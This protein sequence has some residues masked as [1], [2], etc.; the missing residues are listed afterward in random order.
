MESL[1]ALAKLDD[2][3]VKGKIVFLNAPVMRRTRDGSGYGESVGTRFDGPKRAGEKGA[4]AAVIRSV[5]T[6]AAMPHT[7]ATTRK[8]TVPG[9]ALSGESADALHAELAARKRLRLKVTLGAK[10]LEPADSFNVIGEVL[11]KDLPD[12]VVLMGAHLDSWDVGQGAVDDGAGCAIVIEAAR[13]VARHGRAPKR[14]VRVVL[15]AAEEMGIS[16]GDAYAEQHAADAAKHIVALEAD[17]GTGKVWGVRILGGA[18]A[19][20]V[21]H[22]L[23]RLVLPLGIEE[24][25]APARG[26]ADTRGMVAK[27]VPVV[28]FE[29]D[30]S[31]YFDVHHTDADTFDRIDAAA[32]RQVA[33]AY[34]TAAWVIADSDTDLGRAPEKKGDG[35]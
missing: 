9:V 31:L 32:L 7:G 4:L 28:D 19:P 25:A 2:A 12:E 34:A 14:T 16:G 15:F 29:Q 33:A 1:D 26:G 8:A 27:G 17:S 6:D 10:W 21:L 5:G 35:K 24:D 18:G 22:G 11:G 13:L 23:A 30:S 20:G 3:K